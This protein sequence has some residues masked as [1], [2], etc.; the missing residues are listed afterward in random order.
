MDEKPRRK[1]DLL[2]RLN[3]N[4]RVVFIDDES[5]EEVVS[6][7]LTMRKLYIIISTLFVLV[8]MA[9]VAIVVL[10]P[11]KYYIPGYAGGKTRLEVVKLKQ[12]VDSLSDLVAAQ[13]KYQENLRNVIT[14][15]MK[16]PLDTTMLDLKKTRQEEINSLLPA[17]GEL[18]K[19]AARS[20]KKDKEKS[21]KQPDK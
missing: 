14:G 3:D 1:R 9:T 4:Y 6:F 21:G 18:M 20:V 7:R 12:N 8:A 19:Q 15:N 5:L 13:E 17:S 2:K 16:T 10:T 11:V